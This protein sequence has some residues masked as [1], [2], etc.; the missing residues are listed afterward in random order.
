MRFFLF[1]GLCVIKKSDLFIVVKNKIQSPK[2]VILS[3]FL[4]NSKFASNN[5]N[6]WNVYQNI[7][8]F[9]QT[10]KISKNQVQNIVV[11]R[12]ILV[13]QIQLPKLS[14]VGHDGEF[15]GKYEIEII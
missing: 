5:G 8:V 14:I 3:E 9:F 2:K 11:I 4:Q 6:I 7:T 1:S 12:K 15:G 13:L 10:P